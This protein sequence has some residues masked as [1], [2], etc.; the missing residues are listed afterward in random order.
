MQLEKYSKRLRANKNS[1]LARKT[2]EP[3]MTT[4]NFRLASG[5][6]F[7]SFHSSAVQRR[8]IIDAKFGFVPQYQYEAVKTTYY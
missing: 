2:K 8:H 7:D 1:L 5:R 3:P 6:D 4:A